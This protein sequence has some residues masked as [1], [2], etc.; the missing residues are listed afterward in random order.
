MTVTQFIYDEHQYC[1]DRFLLKFQS[2]PPVPILTQFLVEHVCRTFPVANKSRSPFDV[3][4]VSCSAGQLCWSDSK[5]GS[6]KFAARQIKCPEAASRRSQSS[7]KLYKQVLK[8]QTSDIFKVLH[9][10]VSYL[11]TILQKHG[12]FKTWSSPFHSYV[13]IRCL[14]TKFQKPF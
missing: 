6:K 9:L 13:A 7:M 11:S 1:T 14:Q 8:Q 5:T 3:E 10:K 12:A 2:Q 4:K